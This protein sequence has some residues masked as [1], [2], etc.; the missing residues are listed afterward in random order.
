MSE[1]TDSKLGILLL[2]YELGA[3][4]A[5]E[6]ERFETH[7]L[8]C[9]YCFNELTNFRQQTTLL[10]NDPEVRSVTEAKA[11]KVAKSESF[12]GRLRLA[13]WPK[14]PFVLKPA[15]A[16]L[17]VLL[18][19]VPAYLGLK[20]QQGFDIGEVS[21]TLELVQ[22]RGT[23]VRAFKKSL[24]DMALL[25]FEFQLAEPDKS[26]HLTIESESGKTIYDNAE[27]KN[28]D[29]TRTGRLHLF[30]P[31]IEHGTYRLLVAGPHV[32]SMSI[33]QEYYFR[34]EE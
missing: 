17:L 28:F 16:Y 24:G 3:L 20:R 9:D 29:W 25:T 11:R 4:P 30:L 33:S 21:Q 19:I 26:Y 23:S 34:V 7:L 18:M 15:V 14:A 2:A 1:C 31:D 6:T 13:L 12:A 10:A 27:F 22:T 32:D 8:Q 5:E